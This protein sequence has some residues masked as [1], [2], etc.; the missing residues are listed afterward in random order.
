MNNY[1]IIPMN[2]EQYN[3]EQMEV[4]WKENKKIMWQVKG[5]PVFK[6]KTNTWL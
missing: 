2:F 6:K 4:E 3:F 5:T 1:W